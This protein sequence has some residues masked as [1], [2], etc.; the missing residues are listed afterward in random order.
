MKPKITS[1]SKQTVIAVLILTAMLSLVASTYAE[2]SPQPGPVNINSADSEQLAA[3]PGIGSSK[4]EAIVKYRSE[5]GPFQDVNS[6]TNVRG[7]GTKLLE[8]IL[9]LITT[10]NQ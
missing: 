2:P 7:I 9:P 6:L 8:N 4:A 3:L 1:S 10:V 5:H